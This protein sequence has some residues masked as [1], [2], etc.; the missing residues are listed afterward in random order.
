MVYTT[1]SLILV[2]QSKNEATWLYRGDHLLPVS[3]LFNHGND[4]LFVDW[5]QINEA[6]SIHFVLPRL[7]R[8]QEYLAQQEHKG[9]LTS[10][11]SYDSLGHS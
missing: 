7:A 5:N 2:T 11:N 6:A 1:E 4:N 3:T 8:Q 9:L 10:N